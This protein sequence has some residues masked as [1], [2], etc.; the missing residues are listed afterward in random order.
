MIYHPF[1]QRLTPLPAEVRGALWPGIDQLVEVGPVG[2]SIVLRQDSQGEP[3]SH[4]C[5]DP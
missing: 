3:A 4:S 5:M 2:T 1:L